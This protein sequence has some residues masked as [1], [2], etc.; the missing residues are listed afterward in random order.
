MVHRRARLIPHFILARESVH[1]VI[2]VE[3]W[4]ELITQDRRKQLY[5]YPP[6]RVYMA[7]GSSFHIP[8]FCCFS[9][10]FHAMYKTTVEIHHLILVEYTFCCVEQSRLFVGWLLYSFAVDGHL[11]F[12][13]VAH[14]ESRVAVDNKT[15]KGQGDTH[16]LNFLGLIHRLPRDR[17]FPP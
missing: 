11:I 14:K 5:S 7:V 16:S 13:L 10:S 12:N 4:I 9:C 8:Q 15:L 6:R 1:A 3:M 2:V 17:V